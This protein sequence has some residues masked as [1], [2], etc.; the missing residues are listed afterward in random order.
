MPRKRSFKMRRFPAKAVLPDAKGGAGT[1]K[2]HLIKAIH[3]E[4]SRLLSQVASSPDKVSVLLTAPTGIAAYS[5]GASTIHSTFSIGLDV[6][7]PYTP[8]GEERVSTLRAELSDLQI[9]VIDEISMVNHNL[10]AYVHGRLRQIKQISDHS[11]FGKVS[12]IAVGDFFQL[13]PVQGKSLYLENMLC[14]FWTEQFSIAHL[15]TI[16]RQQDTVFA[17][18]LNRLRT[19][20]KTTA[21]VA[22][23]IAI[24]KKCETG[25]STSALHIFATNA[26]VN[27][28]N[29]RQL[30]ASCPENLCVEALDYEKNQQSGRMEL[31]R[32]H[33]RNVYKSYL[34][35]RLPLGKG[36]RVMLIKNI[37]VS[38]GLV[39]GV[40]GNVVDIVNNIHN[41][42]VSTVFVKFD[43]EKVGTNRR[44]R[45]PSTS[46]NPL[47]TPINRDDERIR[48]GKLRKQFPLKLAWACTIHKVQGLTVD[49]AVVSL[50]RIFESGQAYV[51]LSRVKSLNGLTIQDFKDSAIYCKEN[52]QDSL[53][54]MP[55]FVSCAT[56]P[57]Q[58]T[59]S[60]SIFSMNVQSLDRHLPDLTAQIQPFDYS[61]VAVTETWLTETVANHTAGIE[62]YT[63]HSVPRCKAYNS[64]D[65]VL[66][67][68]KDQQQGGVGIYCQ[69]QLEY[70]IL[71]LP[72]VNLEC[73]ASHFT[74]ENV[75]VVVLYRPQ[76]YPLPLFKLNMKLL[77]S[78]LNTRS[79][80]VVILGDFNH[81]H[82]KSLSMSSFM[83]QLGYLQL[84]SEPTTEKGTLID[85]VYGKHTSKYLTE[86]KVIPMYFSTHEAVQCLLTK[87]TC[88][89]TV[90]LCN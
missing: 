18:L 4:A 48:K 86:T 36:A 30:S 25:E 74:R 17:E 47:A 65:A 80:N 15:N 38:D 78:F 7:P 43:D 23:D 3:Y 32:G 42:F 26:Q 51:A 37:D 89:S 64:T 24:L 39:N 45:F 62:K 11:P 8:L 57:S 82:L 70:T 84:V 41:T 56:T 71:D 46:G 63:F 5:L 54:G 1:G 76:T 34:P 61:C 13:K 55:P 19:R 66:K 53:D 79:D 35:E 22:S 2:S 68:I 77:T 72:N 14:D 12:V 20:A 85:H 6:K 67:T 69:D 40:C 88:A 75:I 58:G 9:L 28:H 52:I 87:N 83:E 81:D 73:I 50:K 10:L 44:K 90:S 21:L 60:F 33:F 27:D 31:K 49:K 29:I 16:V 59:H